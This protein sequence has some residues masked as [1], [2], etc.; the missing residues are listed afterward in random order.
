[1]LWYGSSDESSAERHMWLDFTISFIKFRNWHQCFLAE[2]PFRIQ[3]FRAEACLGAPQSRRHPHH[4]CT[5]SNFSMCRILFGLPWLAGVGSSSLVFGT[6]WTK[7]VGTCQLQLPAG[8][9]NDGGFYRSCWC[10]QSGRLEDCCLCAYFSFR[11]S[12]TKVAWDIPEFRSVPSPLSPFRPFRSETP[13]NIATCR[14]YPG[15]HRAWCWWL[16]YLIID[17]TCVW[18]FA[19]FYP[20]WMM[21]LYM[22]M[23]MISEELFLLYHASPRTQ[24]TAPPRFAS[25]QWLPRPVA[26]LLERAGGPRTVGLHA[27]YRHSNEDAWSSF[28]AQGSQG[29]KGG[30]P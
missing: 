17:G 3:F 28:K 26:S 8:H 9:Y 10:W 15:R 13:L 5:P 23:P 30:R 16:Q 14:Y 1:M 4:G 19:S 25:D 20:F 21:S 27:W 29:S 24:P 2:V 18:R 12:W 6:E 22:M 7:W 11:A